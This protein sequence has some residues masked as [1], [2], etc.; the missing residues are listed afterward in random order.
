MEC[1]LSDKCRQENMME[2]T[3]QEITKIH[4]RLNELESQVF[5]HKNKQCHCEGLRMDKLEEK[6]KST[7][8]VFNMCLNGDEE[9]IQ[10]LEERVERSESCIREIISRLSKLD[11][12]PD[13]TVTKDEYTDGGVYKKGVDPETTC[14]NCGK[15][16]LCDCMDS[17]CRLCSAPFDKTRCK[18]FNFVPSGEKKWKPSDDESKMIQ[19]MQNIHD[20]AESFLDKIK[21][22][23]EE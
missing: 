19:M 7:V 5:E 23:K 17:C 15:T 21:K 9:R 13:G 3:V 11:K 20:E 16:F 8:D 12:Q 6:L 14:W 18:E 10:K 4:K 2:Y 22:M 1:P